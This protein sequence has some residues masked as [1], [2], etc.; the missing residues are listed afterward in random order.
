[1]VRGAGVVKARP[2]PNP[3]PQSGRGDRTGLTQAQAFQLLVVQAEEV[4]GFVEEGRPDLLAQ[5][6]VAGREA[7]EIAPENQD[8]GQPRLPAQVR[9]V[10]VRRA[11]EQPE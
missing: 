10:R 7:L 3:L 8:L 5:L 6:V 1:M 4:A 11:A 9:S 2:H